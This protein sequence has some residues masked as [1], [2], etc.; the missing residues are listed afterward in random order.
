MSKDVSL[1]SAQLLGLRSRPLKLSDRLGE[2]DKIYRLQ[3][4]QRS[5]F[6][7]KL[8][9]FGAN[10][11]VELIQ[12]RDGDGRAELGETIASSRASEGLDAIDIQ[13]LSAGT[14]YL[15][16]LPKSDDEMRYRLRLSAAPTQTV[17]PGYEVVQLTNA[18]RESKGLPALAVNTQL[19]KA[20]QAYARS[21]AIDD[22]WSHTGADGSSPWDRIEAAGYDY[23]QAAENLAA[24]HKTAA[25]AVQG[26]INS[27]GHRRNL[28]AYQ[29]QEIGV[30]YFVLTPDRGRVT[31][32]SYW[33]QSMGTPIDVR[34]EPNV[35]DDD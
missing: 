34:V 4:R 3:L 24:G 1:E 12:D 25:S 5:S 18:Y 7:L 15:R 8:R 14:Y 33:S 17:S 28:L 21:L 2:D 6:N 29:V 20:A 32:G 27:P 26:W 19:T 30:G 13:G 16:V 10:A 9:S 11:D 31:F 35:P 22:N 23:S